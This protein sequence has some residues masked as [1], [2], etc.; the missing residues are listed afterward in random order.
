M[1]LQ[2]YFFSVEWIE[3]EQPSPFAV[4]FSSK[5]GLLIVN[6]IYEMKL[7]FSKYMI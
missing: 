7:F 6:D 4:A 3:D 1:G 5:A 2:G